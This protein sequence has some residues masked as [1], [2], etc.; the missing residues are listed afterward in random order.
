MQ[1]QSQMNRRTLRS[2]ILCVALIGVSCDGRQ[3][4]TRGDQ[5]T[6]CTAWQVDS[7]YSHQVAY[8]LAD[9]HLNEL[10]SYF[11]PVLDVNRKEFVAQQPVKGFGAGTSYPQIWLRDS[12]T[13]IPASRFY[14]SREY[15]QSWLEEHLSHQQGDGQLYDWIAAGPRASF[16][17]AAP[18]AKEIYRRKGTNGTGVT[19]TADKNS[20]ESDQETSAI[21]AAW[22]LYQTT[23]DRDWLKKS[24]NGRALI[25]RLN[26]ALEFLFKSK[27]DR[28]HGLVTSAF[29]IDWGDVSPTYPDQRAI[30][31][32]SKTPLVA[33]IYTNALVYRAAKQLEELNRGAGDESLANNWR[34]QAEQIKEKVNKHLWQPER[35]FYRIHLLLTPN[36]M[37]ANFD[38]SNMFAM[39]GN[40]MAV[41]SGVADDKQA[42]SIFNIAETRQRG[43]GVSTISGALLPPFPRGFFKHPAVSEEYVYQ[44]GGQWDWFGARLLLAEF[45]Q[46]E[47]DNAYRSLIQIAQKISTNKGLYEWHTKTGEGRG[48]KDY[49]GNAGVLAAAVFQG[50][51][52]V[53]LTAEQLRLQIRLGEQPGQI[54]LYE[55][56]TDRFVA[57]RYCYDNAKQTI[58]LEYESNFPRAGA[59]SLR[60]P[61][62]H[63]VSELTV[64]GSKREFRMERRGDDTYI[65]VETDW[66]RHKLEAKLTP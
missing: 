65:V 17:G 32:D 19:V 56:S 29:A 48:S 61:N 2:L 45:E 14:Y 36:L 63:S 44:N 30:Y 13:I 40:A 25:V 53:Y 41:L 64:D 5:P 57:Y 55:P 38:D 23:G 1:L 60:V 49:A 27:L 46:G 4:A 11:K 10:Q 59:I 20:T 43:F 33:G 54:H 15:L 37:P 12:A 26:A 50:L 62:D 31:L 66:Q 6:A 9:P 28:E 58:H 3:P 35:G 34:N 24:I 47:S 7:G 39:G 18:Q 51:F 52:G 16:T 21:D 22:Q 8:T 42:Q